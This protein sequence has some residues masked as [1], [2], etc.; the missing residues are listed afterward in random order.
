MLLKRAEDYRF[1][2]P[3]DDAMEGGAHPFSGDIY[4][5]RSDERKKILSYEDI[6]F[7]EEAC[8]ELL[9]AMMYFNNTA[10]SLFP[11][12][13]TYLGSMSEYESR[14][15]SRVMYGGEVGR[16]LNP[17]AGF[18]YNTPYGYGSKDALYKF[19]DAVGTDVK[20]L[21]TEYM[22]CSPFSGR[23]L[24]QMSYQLYGSTDRPYGYV[25]YNPSWYVF[26]DVFYTL[27]TVASSLEPLKASADP[28]F[29]PDGVAASFGSWYVGGFLAK[30]GHSTWGIS[31]WRVY[32]ELAYH[33]GFIY[34]T[35][36]WGAVDGFGR[37]F[38]L[39]VDPSFEL[40][41]T[42][43]AVM[44]T[45]AE[46]EW[47]SWYGRPVNGVV[48]YRVKGKEFTSTE[49][50]EEYRRDER[51]SDYDPFNFQLAYSELE[52]A[53]ERTI[54]SMSMGVVK[55]SPEVDITRFSRRPVPS[56]DMLAPLWVIPKMCRRLFIAHM[57]PNYVLA[58]GNY[59]GYSYS[60]STS[61]DNETVIS[62]NG[63]EEA[64][65]GSRDRFPGFRFYKQIEG[66]VYMS[67]SS[68]AN[69]T[70][71]KTSYT[72][73][74]PDFY[75]QGPNDP[76][77]RFVSGSHS[78]GATGMMSA[79]VGLL[80]TVDATVL[81]TVYHYDAAWVQ[82]DSV[83]P[84]ILRFESRSKTFPIRYRLENPRFNG[85]EIIWT[86]SKT[87]ADMVDEM[88]GHM[89]L[90]RDCVFPESYLTQSDPLPDPST[91]S[92]MPDIT[93]APGHSA[94]AHFRE[95]VDVKFTLYANGTGDGGTD[96]FWFADDEV[97]FGFAEISP[98]TA[99]QS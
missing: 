22:A 99:D 34:F 8:A 77:V 49:L 74:V 90:D 71:H 19:L 4:P 94:E 23:T 16:I 48:T 6:C 52:G 96:G 80:K 45:D 18:A 41:K 17:N 68:G 97:H 85:T 12:G 83:E 69:P 9:S 86:P 7:L 84:Q 28:D 62:D 14:P 11:F 42:E 39:Y 20:R 60:R 44:E 1:V 43:N 58:D 33:D 78:V 36:D 15:V 53:L 3:D 93:I 61:R 26:F 40:P 32:E 37:L 56:Q 98:R 27:V 30:Y 70:T 63:P 95:E 5:R 47:S 2:E 21:F 13:S 35:W 89:G 64:R 88:L 24:D 81:A 54:P 57:Q 91:D 25:I 51:V 76:S 10:P 50:Q 73:V 29:D 67:V 79:L 72:R 46:A 31:Y 75:L 59:Y 38:V 92:R 87:E 82:L 66:S 55:L 65:P